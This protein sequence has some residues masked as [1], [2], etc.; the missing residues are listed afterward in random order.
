MKTIGAFL[1]VLMSLGTLVVAADPPRQAKAVGEI[2]SID[3][4]G[5]SVVVKIEGQGSSENAIFVVPDG[6]KILK[7]GKAA[8]LDD[9]AEGDEVTVSY[10]AEGG[11]NVAV[12]IDIG[13]KR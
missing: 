11:K 3:A 5:K 9:L 12:S 6:A 10:R 7:E 4:A 2:V 8:K 1:T 13:S